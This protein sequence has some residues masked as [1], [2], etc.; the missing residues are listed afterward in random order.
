[1]GLLDGFHGGYVHPRRVRV[2]ANHISDFLSRGA[3]VLDVGCGDGLIAAEVRRKRPDVTMT[4]IDV[5]VRSSAHIPVASFDGKAIPY[6]SGTFESVLLV[7]VL[8]HT[9]DPSVLLR[10][11]RRV[12]RTEVILKDHTMDGPLSGT[13][14]R[15][16][17]RVGNERHGVESVY[18]Y[19][20]TVRWRSSFDELGLR[21]TDWVGNPSLYPWPASFIFGRGLHFV[22]RLVPV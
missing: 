8:H 10:E 16:M 13:L 12:A 3:V 22:A 17:D 14:L 9:T 6:E 18:N 21:V 2:L 20:P 11:A 4:G 5:L 1:M 7:D 15:F 19:W